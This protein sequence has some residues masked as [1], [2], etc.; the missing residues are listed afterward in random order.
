MVTAP[1]ER[2][3]EYRFS[4]IGGAL[5]LDFTNTAGREVTAVHEHLLGY[6][7]LLRW[8]CQ[9]ELLDR[10]RA[11]RLASAA[12]AS[13]AEAEAVLA[14]A[15]ELR[16]TIYR[17]FAAGVHGEGPARD[18][19]ERL[20]GAL[21]EAMKRSRVAP[22]GEGFA[23]GWEESDALDCMLWPVL[24]SAAELLTSDGL[25]RIKECGS[26]TCEWL[27]LDTTKNRRRRWCEMSSCGN[28]AKVRRHRAR[29]KKGP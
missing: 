24:R 14:R 18:D 13:P 22:R 11:D 15:R 1:Q 27:F 23:W 19:L 16:E 12:T 7:D 3:G 28:L 4:E 8:A 29:K 9:L 20:N 21:A 6:A 25:A 5:C 2:P 17:I 26:D 10:A